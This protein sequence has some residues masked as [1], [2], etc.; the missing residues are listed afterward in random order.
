MKHLMSSKKT[1]FSMSES[2]LRF[3]P[4]NLKKDEIIAAT[5]LLKFC[6]KLPV[7]NIVKQ[8]LVLHFT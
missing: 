1:S 2:S 8:I 6:Y 4:M 7:L 5:L 3:P